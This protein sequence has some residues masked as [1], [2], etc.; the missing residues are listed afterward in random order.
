MIQCQK[1]PKR[2]ATTLPTEDQLEEVQEV[3]LRLKNV[4]RMLIEKDIISASLITQI[5]ALQS[6]LKAMKMQNRFEK[7]GQSE[8]DVD[9]LKSQL[10]DTQKELAE[11]NTILSSLVAQVQSLQNV[12]EEKEMV[13][14]SQAALVENFYSQVNS[15]KAIIGVLEQSISNLEEES[16]HSRRMLER[17]VFS[18]PAKRRS[19]VTQMFQTE[20]KLNNT[21]GKP[22]PNFE[23]ELRG[24]H[25]IAG[26]NSPE[27]R[28][29]E[30]T[31]DKLRPPLE[32]Q[33]SIT[34]PR[35][36]K[37]KK[38]E[39][40]ESTMSSLD[41][42]VVALVDSE[43][44]T[45][46][47]DGK[48][49]DANN[50]M[51]STKKDTIPH[52]SAPR[53]DKNTVLS[54]AE[55]NEDKKRKGEDAD[56]MKA[57]SKK[58]GKGSKKKRNAKS[59]EKSSDGKNGKR[60]KRIK[61]GKRISNLDP[62]YLRKRFQECVKKLI[63]INRAFQKSSVDIV[64]QK[65]MENDRISFKRSSSVMTE[66][67]APDEWHDYFD[68]DELSEGDVD[69]LQ[70][71]DPTTSP[72]PTTARVSRRISATTGR[73]TSA[74][75]GRRTSATTGK[76]ASLVTNGRRTSLINGKRVPRRLSDLQLNFLMSSD[77]ILD[78]EEKTETPPSSPE[79]PSKRLSSIIL[80]KTPENCST[81]GQKPRQGILRP[82]GRGINLPPI[83]TR[84]I[85]WISDEMV[86]TET[87]IEKIAAELKEVLWYTAD[88][89]KLFS[90][91]KYMEE[92][93]E[94]YEFVDVDSD[95]EDEYS[96]IE[97]ESYYSGDEGIEE[98]IIT[99]DSY[100]EIEEAE[101]IVEEADFII[102][103]RSRRGSL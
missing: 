45:A 50:A 89:Y 73:R 58:K 48:Q 24:S 21:E 12:V 66:W 47:V 99:E 10:V 44:K 20:P 8:D 41:S 6:D 7:G 69:E 59:K 76:R 68:D 40:P 84:S 33:T 2:V 11:K 37:T 52:P 80:P 88:E 14:A 62:E 53:A 5:E 19:P 54:S 22:E 101:D 42:A 81:P 71:T 103:T 95:E 100:L 91:E 72:S 102:S 60:K 39:E 96:Y 32:I 87:L 77:S 61:K 46:V 27:K 26:A 43:A 16:E 1:A 94:E 13:I 65:E 75:T 79:I 86:H 67:I 18:S 92:H 15:K 31:R 36:Q 28:Q 9:A 78:A 83:N 4:N 3:S 35:E 49:K 74:T 34:I 23:Q 25:I 30:A 98:I 17:S 56:D 29:F 90:F 97:E 38:S 70:D 63:A 57:E 55:D 51:S 64:Y 85:T 93:E 82:P